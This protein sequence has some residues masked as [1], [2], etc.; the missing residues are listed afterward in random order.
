M[1]SRSA[2]LARC[3]HGICTCDLPRYIPSSPPVPSL[4]GGL[5]SWIATQLQLGGH[6]H[7]IVAVDYFTK[8]AEAMPIVKS[9]GETGVHFVFNQIIT[10]FGILKELVTNHGSDFQNR[11]M[12]ALASKLGYKQEHSSSYYPQVNGQ[13]EAVNK[14]LKSILQ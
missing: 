3:L 6:H 12:E 9:D 13:V 11:M 14:S 1:R 4:S 8:W 5:I 7:I 10:R 2:T